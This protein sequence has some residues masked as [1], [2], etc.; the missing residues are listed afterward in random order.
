M[1]IEEEVLP[2]QSLFHRQQSALASQER[3][4][5]AGR[6]RNSQSTWYSMEVLDALCRLTK[7]EDACRLALAKL[8]FHGLLLRIMGATAAPIGVRSV[9]AAGLRGPVRDA[10]GRQVSDT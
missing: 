7:N 6:S 1:K 8:G 2:K 4:G 5:L 9:C 3:T 10:P